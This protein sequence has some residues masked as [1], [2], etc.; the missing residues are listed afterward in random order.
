MSPRPLTRREAIQRILAASA[1][2]ATLEIRAGAQPTL[3]FD[4]DLLKKEI[5]WMRV[6]TAEE[7]RVVTALADLI[8]PEDEF[9]PAASAVGVPDFIDEWVSAPY[10]QQVKDR[11]TIRE[12]LSWLDSE[13]KRRF[14]KGFADAALEEQ[15]AILTD[16]ITEGTEARA[17]GRRFYLLFRDRAT[18]GYYTTPEG[19]KAI[20]YTGNVAL[21]EFPG[22]PPEA[23]QHAGLA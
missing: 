16:I 1:I 3:G 13:S 18:G 8:L 23:L 11:K 22:P 19:W 17:Q 20:G 4:P 6:L 9:G 10:D 5:P 14:H 7:K 21:A 2:L 12:G 15:T